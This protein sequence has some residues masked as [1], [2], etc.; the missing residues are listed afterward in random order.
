MIEKK[1]REIIEE[2]KITNEFRV[3]KKAKDNLER[4]SQLKKLVDQFFQNNAEAYK[5]SDARGKAQK[6]EFKRKFD[7]MMQI[8]EIAGYFN[9][10]RKFDYAVMQLHQLIDRLIEQ[11]LEESKI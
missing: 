11:A 1:A 3:L 10:G 4:N 7:E 6:E 2:L 8:P 5:R 9:A